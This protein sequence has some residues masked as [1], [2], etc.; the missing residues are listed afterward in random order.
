MFIVNKCKNDD[1]RNTVYN[2]N[3][4]VGIYTDFNIAVSDLK[5]KLKH[6]KYTYDE[7][8]CIHNDDYFFVEI[9][10]RNRNNICFEIIEK[11]FNLNEI[12]MK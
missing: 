2:I 5:N 6:L 11:K 7:E 1:N 10:N 4:V 12:K 3:S 9:T 8:D